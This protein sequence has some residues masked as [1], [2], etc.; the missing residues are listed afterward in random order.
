MQKETDRIWTFF[1]ISVLG[2]W[3]LCTP[4][5]F[6][7]QS[8]PLTISN[9]ICGLLL[10]G[11]G[12]KA[13]SRPKAFWIWTIVAIGIWLQFTPLIFWAPDAAAYLNDT[14]VGSLVILLSLVLY[15]LPGQ[16]PDVEPS[17]PPGWSFNPSSWPQR[18]V[19][20]MFA[21]AC[22]MISRYLAAYQ[23]GY[24]DTIWDPF[25]SPGTKAVLESTVSKAFPVPDAGLGAMAYTLE[26]FSACIGGKNRWRTAPW[27]VLIFG[28]LV[29]PVS[30]VSVI[31]IILQPL[32]VG[33][34]CTLCLM[35]AV[36]MLI[37]I[38]FAISEVAAALQYLKRSK[39]KP[40]F[41]LLFQ[42]GL[43]PK[44]S[45]DTRTPSLSS[46]LLSLWQSSLSGVTVP[47]NLLASAVVG[48]L[49]MMAPSIFGLTGA[50]ADGDPIAGALAVVVSV[51]SMSEVIRPMRRLNFLFGIWMLAEIFWLHSTAL[52][53]LF[54]G[55]A[56]VLLIGLSF[57]RGPIREKSGW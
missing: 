51:I 44:A 30:L 38:P 57:R 37:P 33:T 3:L 15:P 50:A 54:H 1:G 47:W 21:F 34:W 10:I 56:G 20:A 13:R 6:G 32:V 24:V 36:C 52:G 5:T 11:L 9:W 53:T 4:T 39:E 28:I 18:I 46:S 22:W 25:F 40:F 16:L 17:V 7:F 26:F 35:T 41:S 48:I 55:A 43:C 45:K 19:I 31:L 29:I 42:G 23:L 27:A 8:R 12:L 14:F 49:L 2:F